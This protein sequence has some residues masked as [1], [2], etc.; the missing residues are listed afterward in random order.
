MLRLL[1]RRALQAVGVTLVVSTACFVMIRTLPG[2]LAFRIAAGRYGYDQVDAAS[3]E[4]VRAELGLDR[5]AWQQLLEWWAGLARL[6]LGTSLVTRAS[7]ADE[8]GHALGASLHLA[9]VA[10]AMG[11]LVGVTLGA[12]AAH[13]PG[14]ALDKLTTLAVVGSRALPPFILGLLLILVFAVHLGVLPAAGHGQASNVA[15][16]AAALAI[17]LAGLFARITRDTVVQVRATEYVQFARTKGLNGRLVLTRHVLR[18]SGVTVVSY[19]GVQALILIEGVIVIESLFGWPGLG[20]AL[21]HAVFWRDVPM[22]QAT[23]VAL[24]L[25]VVV[26]NTAVDVSTAAMDPRPRV[27]EVTP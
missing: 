22:I 8:L 18:N 12:A 20:H 3:A 23:A 24:A 19:V 17:G 6:D 11:C 2:D 26:I 9:A 4:G 10:L 1:R 16:P 5:P 14:G 21:V 27:K 13:R 15:L 7:I 25:L